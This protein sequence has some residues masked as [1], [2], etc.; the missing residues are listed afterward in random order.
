MKIHKGDTVQIIAGKDAGKKGKV[1][2][3]FEKTNSVLVPEINTYKKH[4]KKSEGFPQGG[5]VQLSRPLD[6][7]K[8]SFVCPKCSKASRI[9]Y[10]MVDGLKKRFCKKCDQVI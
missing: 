10:K 6:T 5:I 2:L 1:E 7:S 8:V 9:G 4:V 3:V